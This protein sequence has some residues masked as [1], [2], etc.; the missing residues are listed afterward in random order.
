MNSS[1]FFL[2]YFLNF[3]VDEIRSYEFKEKANKSPGNSHYRLKKLKTAGI[4][5]VLLKLNRQNS[6][7]CQWTIVPHSW[8][9][10]QMRI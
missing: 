9:V 10:K 3:I 2:N 8:N 4:A 5:H 7:V 6:E 1:D